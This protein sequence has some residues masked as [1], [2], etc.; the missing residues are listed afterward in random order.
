MKVGVLDFKLLCS[1]F[2]AEDQSSILSE[3][4]A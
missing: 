4:V 3:T 2:S 1:N